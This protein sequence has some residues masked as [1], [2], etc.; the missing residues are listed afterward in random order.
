MEIVWFIVSIIIVYLLYLDRLELKLRKLQNVSLQKALSER[1]TDEA[2]RLLD[3]RLETIEYLSG[4]TLTYS[5]VCNDF[6][7]CVS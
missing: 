5:E 7:T 1:K 4:S 2:R 3:A 6:K